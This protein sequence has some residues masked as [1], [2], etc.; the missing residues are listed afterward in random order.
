M[1]SVKHNNILLCNFSATAFSRQTVIR[2][3]LH[4]IYNRLPAVHSNVMSY[5][6]H[7]MFTPMLKFCYTLELCGL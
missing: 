3:S 7:D 1:F 6:P 2:P 4:N 5:G